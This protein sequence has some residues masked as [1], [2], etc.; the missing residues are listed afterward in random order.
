MIRPNLH[1]EPVRNEWATRA[2]CAGM[3]VNI[4]HPKS[5][6]LPGGVISKEA[7]RAIAICNR[8]EVRTEC[9]EDVTRIEGLTGRPEGIYGGLTPAQRH[10]LRKA[11]A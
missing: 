8:C 2:A 4:F 6:D 7:K 3:D 1:L 10:Q 5:C 11:S 9:L